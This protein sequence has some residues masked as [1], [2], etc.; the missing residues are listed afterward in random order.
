MS[1]LHIAKFV[2]YSILIE[3]S[4]PST[5]FYYRVTPET[6]KVHPKIYFWDTMEELLGYK[7]FDGTFSFDNKYLEISFRDAK[8]KIMKEHLLSVIKSKQKEGRPE[9]LPEIPSV[10]ELAE[11]IGIIFEL[12]STK[13]EV[14]AKSEMD[15]YMEWLPKIKELKA[16]NN[17]SKEKFFTHGQIVNHFEDHF[18]NPKVIEDYE[19]QIENSIDPLN[20]HIN[21]DETLEEPL[22]EHLKKQAEQ[23]G[24]WIGKPIRFIK[25]WITNSLYKV[26]TAPVKAAHEFLSSKNYSIGSSSSDGPAGIYKNNPSES[27]RG[28]LIAKWRNLDR[29]DIKRLHGIEDTSF[30]I[31]DEFGPTVANYCAIFSI[32]D[33]GDS[34]TVRFDDDS[35]VTEESVYNELVNIPTVDKWGHTNRVDGQ[36]VPQKVKSLRVCKELTR[37]TG[38][39]DISYS[40]FPKEVLEDKDFCKYAVEINPGNLKAIPKEYRDLEICLI[41]V[42]KPELYLGYITPIPENLKSNPEIYNAVINK[43]DI[44]IDPEDIV[45]F[46]NKYGKNKAEDII[47]AF[48]K[49]LS[50][51]KREGSW[52]KDPKTPTELYDALF[53]HDWDKPAPNDEIINQVIQH[54]GWHTD[55]EITTPKQYRGLDR[56]AKI[57]A[58]KDFIDS[59][60]NYNSPNEREVKQLKDYVIQGNKEYEKIFFNLFIEK[61]KTGN[62]IIRS[63][64]FIL[65]LFNY[66]T[67]IVNFLIKQVF[68]SMSKKEVDI[69]EYTYDIVNFLKLLPEKVRVS[70][71]IATKLINTYYDIFNLPESIRNLLPIQLQKYMLPLLITT[72]HISYDSAHKID[73]NITQ[74]GMNKAYRE[75]QY[76]PSSEKEAIYNEK[77]NLVNFL[78]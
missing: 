70:R 23:V 15:S 4:E 35:A 7:T 17:G 20:T 18:S 48:T 2:K 45:Q 67:D 41:S 3:E 43:F 55:P 31:G 49:Y 33:E 69:N 58:M 16:K 9:P 34:S 47:K 28:P 63:L 12:E 30:Q 72:G 26:K 42:S 52:D 53:F 40:E 61:H 8:F 10:K 13:A 29:D 32:F 38:G 51:K 68:P 71:S 21:M 25:V 56:D 62:L 37:L 78:K 65:D 36:H 64:E 6:F 77:G 5:K 73:S 57:K 44:D 27:A 54:F 74:E 11:L 39:F 22:K 50:Y 75:F 1:K 60:G 76:L 14:F 59:W 24:L 19:K 46:I 66:S